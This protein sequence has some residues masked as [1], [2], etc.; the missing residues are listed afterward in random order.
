MADFWICPVCGAPLVLDEKGKS[1]GCLGRRAHCFDRAKS[2]Y[3]NLCLSRPAGGDD[4]EMIRARTSFLE[5]G[6][7]LPIAQKV[8][9]LLEKSPRD[10]VLDAGCGEGYYTNYLAESM[11]ESHFLGVDLSRSGIEAAAKQAR[12]KDLSNVS[13]A[14]A[15]LFA[16]PVAE[17]SLDAVI[18]LF[19]PCAEEEFL[20]TVKPGGSLILVG[21]GPDHLMGLKKV[22][23]DQPYRNAGREDLPRKMQPESE[24][25]LKYSVTIEGEETIK[26]LFSMTPYYYRTSREDREKL[27][28][29]DRLDTEVEVVIHR[30][31]IP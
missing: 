14:V 10:T 2:G 26:A 17:H 11:R 25:T 6:Y 7:Y 16:L 19:A 24:E 1:Y 20:R 22:L 8:R 30:Y 5:K 28:G 13:Y 4:P 9:E 3:V 12:R 23:Y 15:G 18:S 29:R 31:R 21:A 27:D